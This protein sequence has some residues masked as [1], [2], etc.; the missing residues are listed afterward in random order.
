MHKDRI[1]TSYELTFGM[2]RLENYN[3]SYKRCALVKYKNRPMKKEGYLSF[4]F[5][6]FIFKN[7]LILFIIQIISGTMCM[8]YQ[9]S[10]L[11]IFNI[12]S[13]PNIILKTLSKY[14]KYILSLDA[15][16]HPIINVFDLQVDV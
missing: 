3:G 2:F 10:I 9:I 1:D 8:L 6:F 15:L 11:N 13:K 12:I 5:I 4:F 16:V 7:K 14:L